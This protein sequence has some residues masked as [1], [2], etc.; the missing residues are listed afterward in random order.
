MFCHSLLN[1]VINAVNKEFGLCESA[2]ISIEVNP[3]SLGKRTMHNV[4]KHYV[5]MGINRLSIGVQSTKDAVLRRLG[6]IHSAQ[7]G[8]I[9]YECARSA[10]FSNINLD[11]IYG[12]PGQTYEDWL[13]DLKEAVSWEP[14]HISA[15]LLKAPQGWNVPDEE[16]LCQMY[17]STV[18][19]LEKAGF[20][21]YEVSNFARR[22][23]ECAHNLAYWR[24]DHYLG[25]GASAHSYF[26]ADV[27]WKL[28]HDDVNGVFEREENSPAVRF[29]NE[30]S[31]NNYMNKVEKSGNAIS[32]IEKLTLEQIMCEKIMLR[33][34]LKEGLALTMIT[35]FFKGDDEKFLNEI[36]RGL[37]MHGLAEI[38][39]GMLNLTPKG[40]LLADEIT[41]RLCAFLS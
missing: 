26:S 38:K 5:E 10:G 27:W 18:E 4:F 8:K 22:P 30:A 39:D 33:L 13:A 2:E 32:N 7:D 9:T 21:Q 14:E 28:S 23:K 17:L 15:Y 6:R 24:G 20:Y 3:A 31:L 37:E 34:R 40:F 1:K 16:T 35:P 36:I 41:A 25:L 12:V 19:M 11:L 29:S